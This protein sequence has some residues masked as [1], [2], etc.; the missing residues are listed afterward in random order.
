MN[1]DAPNYS[2][3]NPKDI[4]IIHIE[5]RENKLYCRMSLG[6]EIK[7]TTL[8]QIVSRIVNFFASKDYEYEK[9]NLSLYYEAE[10]Y[11]NINS[12]IFQ[13]MVMNDKIMSSLY[14]IS[15]WRKL[16]TT[17]RLKDYNDNIIKVEYYKKSLGIFWSVDTDKTSP[18]SLQKILA[19]INYYYKKSSIIMAQYN[20]IDKKALTGFDLDISLPPTNIT[21]SSSVRRIP[22]AVENVRNQLS[23]ILPIQ[24]EYLLEKSSIRE[25]IDSDATLEFSKIIDSLQDRLQCRIFSWEQKMVDGNPVV[26]M[27]LPS[28]Y[29]GYQVVQQLQTKATSCILLF[30]T[31]NNTFNII[32]N[33][34][35]GRV[36]YIKTATSILSPGDV[37]IIPSPLQ[38]ILGPYYRRYGVRQSSTLV[39]KIGSSTSL[40]RAITALFSKE[41]KQSKFIVKHPLTESAGKMAHI[42]FARL[43]EYYQ[44]EQLIKEKHNSALHNLNIVD[45]YIDFTGKVR[46]VGVE[47]DAGKIIDVILPPLAPLANTKIR[48][49]TLPL[50]TLTM[51]EDTEMMTYL[52]KVS[53]KWSN[54]DGIIQ[55]AVGGIDVKVYT[56]RVIYKKDQSDYASYRQ[57]RQNERLLT[58][59]CLHRF[60]EWLEDYRS[61]DLNI[62][63]KDIDDFFNDEVETQEVYDF[64]FSE[65]I[66]DNFKNEKIK[67]P[68]DTLMEYK[69]YI[70][71]ESKDPFFVRSFK[72]ENILSCFYDDELHKNDNI[73]TIPTDD[74]ERVDE[75]INDKKISVFWNIP[76]PDIDV[77]YYLSVNDVLFKVKN[78]NTFSSLK[79]SMTA[80]GYQDFTLFTYEDEGYKIFKQG[81]SLACCIG[82]KTTTGTVY[83]GGFIVV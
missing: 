53:E 37:A 50:R 83:T 77:Y 70:T 3:F 43:T 27:M 15:G 4:T 74:W 26:S 7:G 39:G 56:T 38:N 29:G 33:T 61:D 6:A 76:Q 73:Y 31:L 80:N 51:D 66:S 63:D 52:T 14:Q 47:D 13:S 21:L 75:Y 57:Q 58:Q 32:V 18:S 54:N 67:V 17:L 19:S 35:P 11:N 72:N 59:I 41:L 82:S 45:Q 8:T 16:P 5:T 79:D 10:G 55:L 25:K 34:Q 40:L 60:S 20:D 69:F 9:T 44:G 48:L 23:A 68:K 1:T 71:H 28:T 2:E 62:S 65:L 46:A 24:E 49:N 12:A 78:Y 30:K 64:T 22:V 81:S 36:T 42:V